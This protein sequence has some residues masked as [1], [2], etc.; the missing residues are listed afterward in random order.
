VQR[1][2]EASQRSLDSL[3]WTMKN[4]KFYNKFNAKRS[5]TQE[6]KFAHERFENVTDEKSKEFVSLVH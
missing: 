4:F 5:K 2:T 3:W 6:I 1:Q